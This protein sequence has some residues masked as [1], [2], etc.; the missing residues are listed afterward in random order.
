MLRLASLSS[1]RIL[2]RSAGVKLPSDFNCF[3]KNRTRTYLVG[4]LDFTLDRFPKT[5]TVMWT[6]FYHE[7]HEEHEDFKTIKIFVYFVFFVVKISFHY[8]TRLGN[9]SKRVF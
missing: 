2:A 5:C 8:S 7:E 9:R 4:S 6:F 1:T 3:S